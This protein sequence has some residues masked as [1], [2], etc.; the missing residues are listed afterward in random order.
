MTT[1][2]SAPVWSPALPE[3]AGFE[4]LAI[5]TPGLLTHVATIGEGEP[6]VL[7]HGFPQH[8]WQWH[9][10]APAIAAHG[11]RVICPDLRGSGG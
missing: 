11:Y 7:L 9:A 8:W 4:H 2:T 5:K 10:V 1:P 6:V 3:A